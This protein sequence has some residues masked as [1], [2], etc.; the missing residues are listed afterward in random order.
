MIL[1]KS[2]IEETKIHHTYPRDV[3]LHLLSVAVL[4]GSVV[5]LLALLF[6][7]FDVWLPDPLSA[8]LS[9]TAEIN[10][11]LAILI[12]LAPVY[13]WSLW[14]INRD[15]AKH[16]EKNDYRL[17]RWLLYLNIFLAAALL[18]GDMIALS[19]GFLSGG[20]STRF[21]LKVFAVLAVGGAVFAY[22]LFDLRRSPADTSKLRWW[23][24]GGVIIVLGIIVVGFYLSGSPFRQRLLRFDERKVNDLQNIQWQIVNFWQNKKRLPRTLEELKD[25][26][27]GFIPPVDPQTGN[28][29]GYKAA[30]DLSFELCADFNLPS[31]AGLASGV[32]L[33]A[34]AG[35]K[36]TDN[37]QHG[38]GEFCFSRTIDPELYRLDKSV[39]PPITKT[40]TVNSFASCV[41]AGYP[42][43][44]SFPPKCKVSESKVF[45][46]PRRGTFCA[47]VMTPARNP[48][49]GE[50]GV[51][52]TPCDVPL[53][54]V[55]LTSQGQFCGGLAGATCP[56]GYECVAEGDY[57]D[58]GGICVWVTPKGA[59]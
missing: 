20:L 35:G 30:G 51:F 33:P 45:V 7:Y 49:T 59:P 14:F 9:P 24:G 48:T 34:G 56:P 1:E 15:L 38:A 55:E 39:P 16:P 4:Y 37:W 22:Y 32:R 57:P 18:I 19:Y 43:L 47:Q 41:A 12:V 44:E 29:Y 28:T 27:A 21:L 42:I 36:E 17:R 52:P 54:W 31:A 3:L 46:E 8:P 58:A 6:A 5:N 11:P 13:F 53:G 40:V 25:P 50:T 10:W 26:I 23:L 2:N